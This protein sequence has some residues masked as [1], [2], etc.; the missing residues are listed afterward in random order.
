MPNSYTNKLKTS[1]SLR[2][3]VFLHL[4]IISIYDFLFCFITA[5]VANIIKSNQQETI[6]SKKYLHFL[7][8]PK[9]VLHR[10]VI[11]IKYS[12]QNQVTTKKQSKYTLQ[13]NAYSKKLLTYTLKVLKSRPNN[14]ESSKKYEKAVYI[15]S[16]S[17]FF[18]VFKTLL[19]IK[20]KPYNTLSNI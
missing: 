16:T 8:N 20:F 2:S 15:Y 13:N 14:L 5:R 3:F 9:K 11:L 10:I 7:Y 4:C 1:L 12:L 19:T 17:L 18:H 6:T